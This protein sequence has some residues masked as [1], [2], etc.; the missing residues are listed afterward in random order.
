LSRLT[1]DKHPP[2]RPGLQY[3]QPVPCSAGNP[4]CKYALY[5]KI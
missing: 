2:I 1:G 3:L 5:G 4:V